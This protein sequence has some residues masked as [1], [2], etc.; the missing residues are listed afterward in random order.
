MRRALMTS[1]N[2]KDWKTIRRIVQ[3]GN[4]RKYFPLGHEFVTYDSERQQN[5]TWRVVGYDHYTPVD[6][7][8]KH[9]MALESKY[10]ISQN[11]NAELVQYDAPEA[12]YYAESGLNAGQYQFNL[13]A[14]IDESQGG[15]KTLSFTL[16]KSIPQGGII[17]FPWVAGTQSTDV[18]ISTYASPKSTIAIE[19]VAVE[20]AAKGVNLGT[21]NNRTRNMNYT[22]RIRRGSNNY[23]QSALRQWLNSSEIAN[24]LWQPSNV[25]DRPNS[26]QYNGFKKGL[27]TDFLSAVCAVQVP[28]KTN[29]VYEV[30]YALQKT[31][32]CSDKFFIFSLS[33]VVAND[34]DINQD[35]TKIEY[36]NT[37]KYIKSDAAGNIVTVRLRT[38]TTFDSVSTRTST[39]SGTGGYL[40][41]DITAAVVPVCVIG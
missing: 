34:S 28:C 20:E 6:S 32:T 23:A 9:T 4:A 40:N 31:Y 2:L 3:A 7:S 18:M 26:P 8:I 21:A 30:G 35:G 14:G 17:V 39:S 33:E 1:P 29:K 10:A 15:G 25:Y 41:A 13:A 12:L 5:I 38:P 16:N 27:P 37:E 24:E 36:Y 22:Q 19:S 11:G